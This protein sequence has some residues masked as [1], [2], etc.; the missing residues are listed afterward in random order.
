MPIINTDLSQLQHAKLDLLPFDA[1]VV[2]WDLLLRGP[3]VL[4]GDGERRTIN[5]RG[6]QLEPR[7]CVTRAFAV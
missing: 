3:V 7:S 4:F 6:S 2:G 1:Q 5:R